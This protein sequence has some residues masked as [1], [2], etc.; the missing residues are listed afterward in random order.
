MYKKVLF[1]IITI[2]F[3]VSDS[4]SQKLV[5]FSRAKNNG[6]YMKFI[7]KADPT[8]ILKSVYNQPEDSVKKWLKSASGIIITGGEDVHPSLYGKEDE[9]RKCEAVDLY[10]DT[11]EVMLIRYAKKKKIPLLGICRGEQ[12][13]NVV[14]GGSLYT[15]IPTD[16]Q[17][18]VIH[19]NDSKTAKHKVVIDS[20]SLLYRITKVG[21]GLVNS[22]HHQCVDFLSKKLKPS[23]RTEDN[24][25]EAIE[26][27]RRRW[28]ALG[29]QWHPEHLDF[30]N[31]LA[32]NIAKWFVK[33]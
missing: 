25:I 31:P 30:D 22:N 28:N 23:A 7:Q 33:I 19:R 10:R 24:V 3:L 16:I 8:I 13:L 4:F 21:F 27:K 15:D 32:G 11:L 17:N 9:V 2:S 18:A 29:V 1:L 12:I 6:A 20:L 26:F 14:L 5:L